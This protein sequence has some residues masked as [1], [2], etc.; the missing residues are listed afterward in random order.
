MC[1]DWAD[2]DCSK[3]REDEK[4][5]QQGEDDLLAIC[6]MTCRWCPVLCAHGDVVTALRAGTQ[7]SFPATIEGI[8][9]AELMSVGM[10][11]AWRSVTYS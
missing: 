2:Y 1:V 7:I 6:Q 11:E 4:Y 3:A 9:G 8:K 10:T 5:T